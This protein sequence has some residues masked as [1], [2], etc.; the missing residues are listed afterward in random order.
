M[1]V[2]VIHGPNLNL[3]GTREPE[4]YGRRSLDEINAMIRAE[5]AAL[6]L[7]V[8]VEQSNSE[9]AIIDLIHEASGWAQAIVINPAGYTHTSVAIYDALKAVE[10]PAVEVHLSN[11][12]AREEEF[13]HRS[14]TAPACVGVIAGFRAHSYLLALRAVKDLEQQGKAAE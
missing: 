7:E 13:R 8:R 10:L 1:R 3:L 9:G 11:V 12:G 4:W 6:G 14:V 5:A 2:M